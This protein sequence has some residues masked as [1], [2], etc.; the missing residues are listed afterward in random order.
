L[1]KIEY[2]LDSEAL[3]KDFPLLECDLND[4]HAIKTEKASD[5][6]KSIPKKTK[7]MAV[8]L[9]YKDGTQSGVKRF[10]VVR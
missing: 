7:F 9:S 6:Y 3:D 1:D 10:E 5:I 8:R 2:S 4:P